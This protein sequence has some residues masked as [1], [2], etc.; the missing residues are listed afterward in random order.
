MH[1]TLIDLQLC[2][3]SLVM[4]LVV[5]LTEFLPISSSAHLK[6][7]PILFD[8]GDPGVAL[9]AVVE[10]CS[11]AAVIAFFRTE[12][13]G[14]TKAM[15][16][17][18]RHGD[19]RN[20]ESQMGLAILVGT[21]PVLIAGA[22]MKVLIHDFEHS[23]LR[24]LT[25][26]GAVSIVMALLLA[27]AEIVGRRRKTLNHVGVGDGWLIGAAQALAI[28]P[29]VSRSGSTITA[30]MMA[31]WQRES[32]AVFSFLLGIPA[33]GLTGL[34][35]LPDALNQASITG[36]LP[37]LVGVVTA[38][39]VS[40]LTIGLLLTY[41]R[42]NSTWVFVIYRLAFGLFLLSGRVG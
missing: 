35:E 6:V 17:S 38:G 20:P 13:L 7:V 14:I 9:S 41:L 27:L 28:I 24:S 39:V 40:W 23:A 26:I 30:S 21:F 32:A 25:A 15:S 29:G 22:L 33:I 12:L 4:G 3:H 19:W 42:R 2:W 18:L 34:V 37:L 31:G 10:I 5:G 16:R 8:W 1:P 11:T 36:V